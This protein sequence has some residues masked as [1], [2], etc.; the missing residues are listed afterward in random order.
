MAIAIGDSYSQQVY[1]L[2][3]R[4][5][6]LHEHGSFI[7]HLL[8]YIRFNFVAVLFVMK[9]FKNERLS[10]FFVLLSFT[11]GIAN[12]FFYYQVEIAARLYCPQEVNS[13]HKVYTNTIIYLVIWTILSPSLVLAV[14]HE[15]FPFSGYGDC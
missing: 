3:G 5:S 8:D 13:T 15:S 7:L 6:V 2:R 9:P 10:N 14:M 12:L 4:S 11:V 1:F